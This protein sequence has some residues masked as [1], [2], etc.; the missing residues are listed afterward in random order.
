R[1]TNDPRS[2]TTEDA[3]SISE[4]RVSETYPPHGNVEEQETSASESETSEM[5][6]TSDDSDSAPAVQ[7]T[8]LQESVID[9]DPPKAEENAA[10]NIDEDSSAVDEQSHRASNDPREIRRQQLREQADSD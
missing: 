8:D 6:I 2:Q 1:A 4:D 7:L 10:A 9:N 3:P 5:A